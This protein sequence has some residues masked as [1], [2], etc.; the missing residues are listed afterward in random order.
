VPLQFASDGRFDTTGA[1]LR[2][3]ANAPARSAR[4]KTLDYRSNQTENVKRRSIIG[5]G[6]WILAWGREQ[7][8]QIPLNPTSNGL[9]VSGNPHKQ[10]SG[11]FRSEAGVI[12]EQICSPWSVCNLA[13]KRLAGC[14][15]G[16]A[17]GSLRPPR[18]GRDDYG[19]SLDVGRWPKILLDF[20]AAIR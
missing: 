18:M 19:N 5:R 13:Q 11:L 3:V 6:V 20:A 7:Y 16:P 15:C 4:E 14:Q 12:S 2:H 8:K 1:K 17:P 10:E 9:F